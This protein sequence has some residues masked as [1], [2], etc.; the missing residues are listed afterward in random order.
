MLTLVWTILW[1][2]A[3]RLEV[4][5]IQVSILVPVAV[6]MHWTIHIVAAATTAAT[7]LMHIVIILT[8][9]VVAWAAL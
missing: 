5:H 8:R 2:D 6:V 1:I 7:A 4:G 3:K 9:V